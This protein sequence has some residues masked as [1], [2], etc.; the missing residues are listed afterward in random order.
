MIF[1]FS[2]S[3]YCIEEEVNSEA[4]PTV[5]AKWR[6]LDV[7]QNGFF[8]M[9]KIGIPVAL[10]LATVEFIFAYLGFGEG[11]FNPLPARF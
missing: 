3:H 1:P 8:A 4:A 10:A 5:S 2:D 9:L 6:M 11:L 7:G